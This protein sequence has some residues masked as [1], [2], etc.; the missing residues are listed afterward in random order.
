MR[1]SSARGI[2]ARDAPG[3]TAVPGQ[4]GGVAVTRQQIAGY[5]A[6]LQKRGC[7]KDSV[8]KYD[9]DLT[10]FYDFLQDGKEI[11]RSTLAG[12][13]DELLARGYAPRSV[14]AAVSEANGF[15]GWLGLREYQLVGQLDV[16]DDVQPELTRTEYLRLLSTARAL[17]KERTYLLVKVFA[18]TGITVQELPRLTVE[19][20]RDNRLVVTSNGLRQILRIPASLRD[21]LTRYIHR[22]GLAGGPVFVSRNGKPINRTT[23]TGAIQ[24]LARDARVPKEKCNPRCLC[25]LY[26]ATMSGIEA[27]VRLLVEQTYERLLEQEQLATGWRGG[28]G[29]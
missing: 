21:D 20:V 9:R 14:N 26:Q 5:L 3:R 4:A 24:C 28:D 25:K 7:V 1:R 10:M 27:S 17:G 12:W 8:K 6:D 23:V 19:A 18:A 11:F 15:L 13:R 22:A 29:A 2:R 16:G